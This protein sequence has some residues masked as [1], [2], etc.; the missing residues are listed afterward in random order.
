M[1]AAKLAPKYINDIIDVVFRGGSWY[2]YIDSLPSSLYLAL[3]VSEPYADDV[4][5]YFD[6][7]HEVTYTGYARRTIAR[8]L[9]G[10]RATQGDT[11][12][13]SGNSGTTGPAAVQYFPICTTS[14]QLVTHAALVTHSSRET[15]YNDVFCYWRLAKPMQLSNAAP[16]YYPCLYAQGLTIR[17][18]N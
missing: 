16:G 6:T 4:H 8:S 14:S 5:L 12:A 11:T 1:A 18:D 17:L 9:T 7:E 15:Q 13:S 2:G 10:F 3:L